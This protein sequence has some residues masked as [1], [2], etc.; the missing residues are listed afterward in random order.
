MG[1]RLDLNLGSHTILGDPS[2]NPKE[3]IAGRLFSWIVP[4]L[5]A[6]ELRGQP[7]EIRSIDVAPPTRPHGRLEPACVGPPTH[8]VSTHP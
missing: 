2:D 8:S 3:S 7:G 6:G 5:L 1:S 4:T